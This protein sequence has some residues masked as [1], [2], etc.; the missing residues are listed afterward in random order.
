MEISVIGYYDGRFWLGPSSASYFQVFRDIG[1]P[2]KPVLLEK[3][4]GV[5][6]SLEVIDQYDADILFIVD[7]PNTAASYLSQ[8]PL[9]LSLNAV[10]NGRA[11]IVS[12]KVWD[13]YGPIGI[14][15]FLDD[16]SRYLLEG[17]QDPHFQNS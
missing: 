12:R 5:A 8:E 11:Y 13:F 4:E 15:L 10:K 1:L 2:I 9:I 6:F 14:N 7:N 17:K 16:L 3:E